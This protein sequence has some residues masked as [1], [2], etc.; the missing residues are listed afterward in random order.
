MQRN[1]PRMTTDL[2]GSG[3]SFSCLIRVISEIRGSFLSETAFA[4]CFVAGS[5][6]S[7]QVAAQEPSP[8]ATVAAMERLMTEA[9]ERA[10]KSVVAISRV[11]KE[12]AGGVQNAAN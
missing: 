9:I 4:V 5:A 3:F 12:D 7:I 2:H 1:E 10:E 8:L 11:R 6:A